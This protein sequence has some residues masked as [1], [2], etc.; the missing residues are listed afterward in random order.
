MGSEAQRRAA[1]KYQRDKVEQIN[2][3][4]SPRERYLYEWVRMQD[5][6]AGTYVKSV[7]KEAY[8]EERE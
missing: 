2:L 4:F 1:A 3:K 7:L 6:P 8:R 5:E